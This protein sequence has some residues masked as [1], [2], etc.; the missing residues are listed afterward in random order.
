MENQKIKKEM[1]LSRAY[2]ILGKMDGIS[3]DAKMSLLDVMA[4][5]SNDQ[6]SKG[7]DKAQ[8]IWRR[9]N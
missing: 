7:M 5:L 1:D 8:K 4:E 9:N 3:H 2:S 6:Y